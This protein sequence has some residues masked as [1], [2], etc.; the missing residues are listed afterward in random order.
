MIFCRFSGAVHI[1][2]NTTSYELSSAIKCTNNAIWFL[3]IILPTSSLVHLP[4]QIN[5]SSSESLSSVVCCW[6][7]NMKIYSYSLFLFLWWNRIFPIEITLKCDFL[8]LVTDG[9]I[10]RRRRWKICAW[11]DSLRSLCNVNRAWA[12]NNAQQ[13][14]E[15]SQPAKNLHSMNNKLSHERCY[16][17]IEFILS[18]SP[19]RHPCVL[20]FREKLCAW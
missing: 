4:V 15:M 8:F 16:L 17:P 1:F 11:F 20:F 10:G 3:W 12:H 7:A 5:L 19:S 2:S 6:T 13:S 18:L 14:S 9:A